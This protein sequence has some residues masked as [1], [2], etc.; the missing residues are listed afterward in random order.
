MGG[1]YCFQYTDVKNVLLLPWTSERYTYQVCL[2]LVRVG[3]M[4][5]FT[6][7]LLAI[8]VEKTAKTSCVYDGESNQ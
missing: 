5:F 8:F 7:I 2:V 6:K 3:A 4:L 1:Y